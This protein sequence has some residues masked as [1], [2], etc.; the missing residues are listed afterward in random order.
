MGKSYSADLRDRIADHIASGQSRR[1]ASRHFGVSASCAVKLAQR[2]AMTGSSAPARKGRP[3]GDGKLAPHM[4]VLMKWVDAEPDITMPELSAR[5]VA[6]TGVRAHPAS[7][8][9][10]LLKAGYSFKKKRCWRRNA[11]AMM[12]SRRAG[13]GASI[14]SPA[15]ARHRIDWSSS[16]RRRPRRR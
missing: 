13:T 14:G 6:A 3:P 7:L 15:C 16:T 12:L 11:D 5:L 1:S 8:S 2:V 4:A 9:R 10:A